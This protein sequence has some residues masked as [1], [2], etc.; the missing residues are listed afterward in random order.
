LAQTHHLKEW[1]EI[2][3]VLEETMEDDFSYDVYIKCNTT[4]YVLKYP[5]DSK[6]AG[7]LREKLRGL[8]GRRIGILRTD[9]EDEPVMVGLDEKQ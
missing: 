2:V 5:V 1:S 4:L 9:F 6:E 7:I 3:G 8:K